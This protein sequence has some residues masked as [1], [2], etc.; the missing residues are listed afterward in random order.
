MDFLHANAGFP[1]GKITHTHGNKGN[2]R[3]FYWDSCHKGQLTPVITPFKLLKAVDFAL[4]G[5]CLNVC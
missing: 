3:L 4:G 1:R 2:K 5:F